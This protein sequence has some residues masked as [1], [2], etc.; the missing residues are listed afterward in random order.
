MNTNFKRMIWTAALGAAIGLGSTTASAASERQVVAL[1]GARSASIE[2]DMGRGELTL[3]GDA[4]ATN[5][6]EGEFQYD[7]DDWAPDMT[8]EVADANGQLAIEQ[9]DGGGTFGHWPWEDGDSKWDLRLN[10][11]VPTDLDVHLG[12]GTSNIDVS[13]L[14]LDT[15]DVELNAGETTVDLTGEREQDVHATINGDAG[16]LV[17]KLPRDV[18]VRVKVDTTIGNIDETGLTKDGDAYVNDV[19]GTAP[20]AVELTLDLEVGNVDLEVVS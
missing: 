16:N 10:N 6:I 1:Q 8:Y 3:N 9:G 17:V 12:A 13:E 4:A 11:A 15:L 14:H 19:Y 20:V 5:L 2:I 18:G 7:G